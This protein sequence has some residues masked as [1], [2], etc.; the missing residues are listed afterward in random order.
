MVFRRFGR[1]VF[2]SFER[3]PIAMNSV[4]GVGVYGTAEVIAQISVGPH[5]P[6]DTERAAPI[7]A[8]GAFEVGGLMSLWYR[9]L[10]RV[11]GS[12]VGTPVVLAKCALDQIFFA[13]QGD[14]LFI[15][16][17]AYQ[18]ANDLPAAIGEVRKSLV[19]TWINDCAVWPLVNFIGFAA[20]P[21]ALV[22]TYMAGMQL[23]WQIYMSL[24]QQK[25]APPELVDPRTESTLIG[26]A[27][28][29]THMIS[30]AA[31]VSALVVPVD[32]EQLE[33][34]FAEF[35]KDAN[36]AIDAVE[37]R[38]ALERRG[39]RVSAREVQS[40]ILA[41]DVHKRDGTVDLSE[42]KAIARANG[43]AARL[44]KAAIAK[45]AHL[46]EKGSKHAFWRFT[47]FEE[48]RARIVRR[49][50]TDPADHQQAAPAGG[51]AVSTT[52]HALYNAL[53]ASDDD[54]AADPEWQRE[55]ADAL[56]NCAAGLS[57]LAASVV[58]RRAF[59]RL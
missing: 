28:A 10:D 18:D 7:A 12:G 32:D 51:A 29:A 22:P 30:G 35:D 9:L 23:F 3:F 46:L 24:T 53:A 11:V 45:K 44:W 15:A 20:L 31:A 25:G 1:L 34:L 58:A 39:I 36:G 2:D 8:L 6:I 37:L 38:E 21:T 17:C 33:E 27:G 59:F 49:D 4:V 13:T 42:F 26:T 55:R 43:E 14:G 5:S 56:R 52:L 41:A 50:A 16:L 47:Q 48:R 40:M 54:F 19:T 57:L